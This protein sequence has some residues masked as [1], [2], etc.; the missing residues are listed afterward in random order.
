MTAYAFFCMLAWTPPLRSSCLGRVLGGASLTLWSGNWCLVDRH[1]PLDPSTMMPVP[2]LT[3]ALYHPAVRG[4]SMS[5]PQM[6]RVPQPQSLSMNQEEWSNLT[7]PCLTRC[8][9]RL[10]HPSPC[11]S[12]WSMRG[13]KQAPPTVERWIPYVPSLCPNVTL[14][15]QSCLPRPASLS[16]ASRIFHVE[17]FVFFLVFCIFLNCPPQSSAMPA[18][19]LLLSSI[20]P[21]LLLLALAPVPALLPPSTPAVTIGHLASPGSLGT[22]ALTGSDIAPPLLWPFAALHPFS[23]S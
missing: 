16:T 6:E 18:T 1:S 4:N 3:P 10:Y 15:H 22:S 17:C 2:L 9:S 21:W 14:H 20:S 23:C 8:V 11:E 5:L 7:S 13:W 12:L 19:Q